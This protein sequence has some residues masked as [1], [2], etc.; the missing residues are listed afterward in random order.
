[1][2]FDS[3]IVQLLLRVLCLGVSVLIILTILF[4]AF[5]VAPGDPSYILL[6]RHPASE[7]QWTTVEEFKLNETVIVQYVNFMGRMLSGEFF[8]SVGWSSQTPIGDFVFARAGWTALLFG[9]VALISLAAAYA[10]SR[11]A[12]KRTLAIGGRLVEVL[13]VA[14]FTIPVVALAMFFVVWASD[15]DLS[16]F[17]AGAAALLVTLSGLWMIVRQAESRVSGR[18]QASSTSPLAQLNLPLVQ[19]WLAW[20]MVCTLATE[21]LAGRFDGLWST[22]WGS[23]Q[24]R[25]IPVLI[26][27]LYLISLIVLLS[28]FSLDIV[29]L[30]ISRTR[31]TTASHTLRPEHATSA[32][33]ESGESS[34]PRGSHLLAAFWREYRRSRIGT[35]AIMLLLASVVVAVMAPVLSTV[36]DPTS[37][38]S[39]EPELNPLPPSLDE[40]PYSGFTHP[41]G[42]DWMGRDIY[43]HLLYGA[44]E[45]LVNAFV[46][47][48]LAILT[49]MITWEVV[50]VMVRSLRPLA[51]VGAL[52]CTVISDAVIAMSVVV[53]FIAGTYMDALMSSSRLSLILNIIPPFILLCWAVTVKVMIARL[54]SVDTHL[55]PKRVTGPNISRRLM[56]ETIEPNLIQVLRAA[57]FVVV[58]G[59]LS[60]IVLEFMGFMGDYTWGVMLHYAVLWDAFLLGQWWTYLPPL[61]AIVGVTTCIYF[62][63]D[64]AENALARLTSRSEDV[65]VSPSASSPRAP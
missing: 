1:M 29:S 36:P 49:G 31:S 53:L 20:V 38:G 52:V 19:T 4:Q 24:D 65:S 13:A 39:L 64:T 54:S 28:N 59:I 43:S 9:T 48:A 17:A 32:V 16:I 60:L 11:I 61:L 12:P 7:S 10:V 22:L 40:S 14:L 58:I 37:Y 25:N 30:V 50:L 45:F 62:V 3:L 46:L 47:S 55:M 21:I 63:L 2:R 41:L 34:R 23:L 26:V 51:R 44:R 6:P 35:I 15:P 18:S 42:T 56:V 57:K 5:L 27:S 33:P 8:T